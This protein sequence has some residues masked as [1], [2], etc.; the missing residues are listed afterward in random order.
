MAVCMRQRRQKTLSATFGYGF[1]EK[2]EDTDTCDPYKIDAKSVNYTNVESV[3]KTAQFSRE[4][5][6]YL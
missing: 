2:C 3:I 4:G 6:L 5:T 1:D